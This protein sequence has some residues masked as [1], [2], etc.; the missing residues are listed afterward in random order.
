MTWNEDDDRKEKEI[1]EILLTAEDEGTKG[2]QTESEA[3]KSEDSITFIK[4]GETG[5][6]GDE[7]EGKQEE[8]KAPQK[9]AT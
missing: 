9:E 7:N 2:Q 3:G 4:T 6:T 1:S 5:N 8:K